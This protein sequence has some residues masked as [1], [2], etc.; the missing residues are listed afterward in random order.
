MSLLSFF[1]EA[2]KNVNGNSNELKQQIQELQYKIDKLY[3]VV[4]KS[5]MFKDQE[6][7]C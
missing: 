5:S 2:E 4:A 3:S 7:H 6:Q 1:K